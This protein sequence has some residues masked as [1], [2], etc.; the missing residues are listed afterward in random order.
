MSDEG[1]RDVVLEIEGDAVLANQEALIKDRTTRLFFRT[2]LGGTPTAEGWRCPVRSKGPQDVVLRAHRFL[3]DKGWQVRLV[4]EADRFVQREIE[5]R[6]SFE[7]TREK[8]AAFRDEPAR[9]PAAARE[10]LRDFGWNDD[11]RP[12]L[13]HQERAVAHGLSAGNLANFSVPGAGKT[14]ATLALAALH[15]A[16]GTVQ[17]VVVVGPLACFGPWES[18]ARAA[19]PRKLRSVR[20][21]GNAA[22]R[23]RL[24]Q[25]AR[26]LD[27]LLTSYATAAA[28]RDAL[29]ELCRRFD[30][31]L[32]VDES[33]RVKRFRGGL[34]APALVTIA[35]WARVR[36][37][38]SGTP[39]PQSGRDLFSQLSIL[40][41]GGELTGSRDHFAVRVDRSFGAL[42]NDVV[43]FVSRT[44][45]PELGLPP[46][47]IERREVDLPP[48]Q[49]EIYR[50][51]EA[52]LRHNLA[53]AETWADMIAALR[54]GRPIRLLQ[55][56]TNPDLLTRR[57]PMLR[58]P[59]LDDA[60]PT[61]FDRL[62]NYRNEER[63]A[64]WGLALEI[65]REVAARGEKVVCWSNFIAN[66]DGFAKYVA[67]EFEIEVYQVDGRVPA[68]DHSESDVPGTGAAGADRETRERVIARFLAAPR[69]GVLIT[70]PASCS[71]SISLHSTC[72]NAIYMDR[73]YD[74]A[75]FL[76]SIDRIHRLGL[77][78]DADVRLYLLLARSDGRGTIDHLVDQSLE[79]KS[80]NMRRLLEGAEVQPIA[81]DADPLADAEGNDEDLAALLRYLLGET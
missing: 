51:V 79:A 39:M 57:D 28:D 12:L 63:P 17:I 37:I 26:P 54:R 55:A 32:V 33:H 20:V 58:L 11:A 41:P 74:C 60:S 34:W 27:L 15:L 7:R 10:A 23:R 21:R 3:E 13:P 44:S 9:L 35:R 29:I 43:P 48:L 64:K 65:I 72:R 52:R 46:Y 81:L 36:A 45:K 71:E 4:G 61:L 19:L 56:A 53:G 80:D 25:D 30:V 6:R 49:D 18:E 14:A 78:P 2:I 40:W 31:L 66:L 8:A 42:M 22:S 77:P 67:R 62:A 50:L 38:L 76:Q 47:R 73:S 5:R 16:A 75:L 24:Y 70:N 59:R 1:D 69:P 68:G